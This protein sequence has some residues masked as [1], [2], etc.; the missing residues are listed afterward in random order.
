[1]FPVLAN[2][3]VATDVQPTATFWLQS[4]RTTR[5]LRYTY[6]IIY[7]CGGEEKYTEESGGET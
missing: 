6:G 2:E 7:R 5:F 4:T 3:A 1:M